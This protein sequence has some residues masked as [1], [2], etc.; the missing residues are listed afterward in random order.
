MTPRQT[1]SPHVSPAHPSQG[2]TLI[3]ILVVLGILGILLGI[4][5]VSLIGFMNRTRA[6]E[7]AAEL[8]SGLRAAGSRALTTSEGV[9]VNF[10]D[11]GRTL[12]A[13]NAANT[14]EDRRTLPNDAVVTATMPGG[15]IVF[16]GR[17]LPVQQYSV[18]LS[19]ARQQR[20]VVL[21]VTGK[22]VLP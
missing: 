15:P 22:V 19:A 12:S 6:G 5:F 4:G 10:I 13:T 7:A 11:A 21:L 14:K 2:Y 1:A 17:G 16:S 8:A 9:T 20:T 3:E 18:T